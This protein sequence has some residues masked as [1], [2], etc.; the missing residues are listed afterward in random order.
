MARTSKN[1][2]IYDKLNKNEQDIASAENLLKQLKSER[3]T[4]LQEKDDYEMRRMWEFVK[5]QN[6]SLD[7]AKNRLT[8]ISEE[9]PM[10]KVLSPKPIKSKN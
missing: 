3:E 7:E 8:D 6:L 4:L 5:E 2:S 9:H 1:M 10:K